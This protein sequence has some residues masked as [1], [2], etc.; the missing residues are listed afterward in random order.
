M[1]EAPT[2]CVSEQEGRS[3]EGSP[4]EE[5]GVLKGNCFE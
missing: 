3:K 4:K 2:K 5:K 1:A